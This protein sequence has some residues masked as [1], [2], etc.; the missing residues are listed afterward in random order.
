M[1]FN[2]TNKILKITKLPILY[3]Y[4][5]F[6]ALYIYW[7]LKFTYNKSISV[8]KQNF[9]NTAKSFEKLFYI[10]F[11]HTIR[12]MS[13]IYSRTTPHTENKFK[14]KC[15][16]TTK[17]Y[18]FFIAISLTLPIFWKN[19]SRSLSRTR[20]DRPPTNTLVPLLILTS[21]GKSPNA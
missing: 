5:Y 17:A 1:K 15:T 19:L 8:F 16:L 6:G 4:I 21:L 9:F 13:N 3:W 7:I 20:W 11:S 14:K 10:P 2:S 12:Q 18:P